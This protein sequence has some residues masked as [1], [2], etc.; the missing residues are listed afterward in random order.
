MAGKSSTPIEKRIDRRVGRTRA[1]LQQALGELLPE[2]PYAQITVDDICQKAN[3]GRSTFYAHY[4]GKEDLQ[5]AAIGDRLENMLAERRRASPGASPTLIVLEHVREFRRLHRGPLG[6]RGTTVAMEA[7]RRSLME[8]IRGE[9]GV[10]APESAF[11]R[12]LRI[13]YLVG[14]FMEVLIWWLERGARETPEQVEELFREL[15]TRGLAP[16]G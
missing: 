2:K 15:S 3:V 14:A 5:R 6:G 16:S 11:E 4:R 12:D 9:T 8:M 10:T 13:R 7:L 1:A